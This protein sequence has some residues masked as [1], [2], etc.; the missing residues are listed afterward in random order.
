M[1]TAQRSLGDRGE[2]VAAKFLL[3]KGLQLEDHNVCAPG[4]EIDLVMREGSTWV[5]VEVKTRKSRAYG[6]AIE[7]VTSQK[8][9][10][11]LRAVE[12][13]FLVRKNRECLPDFRLDVVGV[14]VIGGRFFCEWWRGVG[15]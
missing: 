1:K 14:E 13:Y 7:A 9:E 11:S 2:A 4:G 6:R 15:I 8:I 10:R 12:H 5:F 3:S